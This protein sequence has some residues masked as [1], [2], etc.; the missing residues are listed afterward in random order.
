MELEQLQVACASREVNGLLS[1]PEWVRMSTSSLLVRVPLPSASN[2]EKAF[3]ILNVRSCSPAFT[4]QRA[5]RIGAV[6][7]VFDF[8][9]RGF[10]DLVCLG[11]LASSLLALGG[12]ARGVACGLYM[13]CFVLGRHQCACM[14][15]RVRA[16]AC[17]C[18][19]ACV[20]ACVRVRVRVRVIV[21]VPTPAPVPAP[22][23]M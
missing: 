3:R 13:G 21:H 17:A 23:P 19:C 7:A 18:A 10:S 9:R 4:R 1:E 8:A 15:V 2:I 16:C 22:V 14:R 20:R 12:L 11:G 5:F 6:D